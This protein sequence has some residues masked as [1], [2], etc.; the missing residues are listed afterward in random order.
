VTCSSSTCWV[1]DGPCPCPPSY[2]SPFSQTDCQDD[3]NYGAGTLDPTCWRNYVGPFI[4]CSEQ[5][6]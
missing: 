4:T 2:A 3:C 5:P 6:C 1:P